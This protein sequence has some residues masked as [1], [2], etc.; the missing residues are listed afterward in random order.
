MSTLRIILQDQLTETIS[1]LDG[2]DK[3]LDCVMMCEAKEEF[4][5]VP[6]HPIKIAFLISAMRLFAEE[7][8]SKGYKVRYV[9]LDGGCNSLDDE[10]KN[11]IEEL[12]PDSIV[13]TE[14]YDWRVWEKIQNWQSKFSIKVEIR[15]DKRFLCSIEE[16]KKW[17]GNKKSLLMEPFYRMMRKKYNILMDMD[18]KPTG[19][20][21]NYDKENRRPPD[22]DMRFPP[23]LIHEANDI[24]KDVIKL[25]EK[26]FQ[27]HFGSLKHFDLATTRN[28][29]LREA[30]FFIDNFLPSF[31]RYQDAMISG[32]A[33]LYHSRLSPYLNAGLLMPLELCKLAQD[34]Y[35]HGKAPLNAVEGFIRQILGWREYIR[36]IYWN[37]MP[38]YAKMNYF[39]ARNPLP[40]FY[41]GKPTKMFCIKEAVSHTEQFA[42]SHHIQRLMVTGNFA[43]LAGINP[44]E[45]EEWYLA[46]YADAYEW[47]E[48]PN[49]LGMALFGDGGIMASKPYAA[50]GK[51]ISRMSN[52]CKKCHYNPNKLIGEDACP[53]NALY[54]HFF[55]LH[56]SKLRNNTRLSFAYLSL[57]KFDNAK[58][59]AIIEQAD[60]VIALMNKGLL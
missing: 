2:I 46:V 48:L 27:N 44:R 55:M 6:H 37:F 13:I 23:R 45:V 32:E 60:K 11:A 7:L 54:W 21:W 57:K 38:A 53:F 41:W 58:K 16:F 33:Y 49:T 24:V 17:A 51:Y 25:V 31:G 43:L 22:D 14:P 10:V 4:T 8:R 56:E 9:P 30:H 3:N 35:R 15:S 40:S 42:Y 5:N 26:N 28:Q 18:G 59:E 36:G 1:S 47:V 50:S 39:E 29:A 20:L 52:F 12:K 34:A 19:G